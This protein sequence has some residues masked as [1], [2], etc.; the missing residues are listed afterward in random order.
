MEKPIDQ[1]DSN[2]DQSPSDHEKHTEN[3]PVAALDLE[4]PDPDAGLSEE[5]RKRIDRRLLWKLDIRWVIPLLLRSYDTDCSAWSHG[6]ACCTLSAFWVSDGSSSSLDVVLTTPDRTNIGN[7]K[8]EGLQEDLK[9]SNQE[10]NNTLTI[11]FVSYS[12]YV[13]HQIPVARNKP[14]MRPL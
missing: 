10:Y 7:A 14:L 4:L 3:K 8:I 5:E 9:M 2:S 6:C 12:L 11:F 1:R 13:Q